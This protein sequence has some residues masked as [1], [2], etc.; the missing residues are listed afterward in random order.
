MDRDQL[1]LKQPGF[2][3]PAFPGRTFYCLHSA[4]VEGVL[5]SFPELALG[6]TVEHVTWPE[7]GAEGPPPPF[8]VLRLGEASRYRTGMYQDRVLVTGKDGV[9]AALSERHG[10]PE[11]HHP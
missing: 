2:A 11:P 9:L 5:S 6:L 3:D 1:F 7:H 4:L 8:L 10:F